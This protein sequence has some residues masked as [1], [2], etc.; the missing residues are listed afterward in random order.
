MD[1]GHRITMEEI[2]RLL[3]PDRVIELKGTTRRQVFS[4]LAARVAADCPALTERRIVKALHSREQTLSTKVS[5]SVAIPHAV[6]PTPRTWVA[7]GRSRA[8]IRWERGDTTRIHIV[9]L[10]TGPRHEHLGAIA[11][12]A[13]QLSRPD[14]VRALLDASGAMDVYALLTQPLPGASAHPG[15][16][17]TNAACFRQAVAL[18]RELGADRLIL[19]ADAVENLDFVPEGGTRP[20]LL[21]VT[22]DPPRIPEAAARAGSVLHIP[23]RGHDRAGQVDAAL[24]Y[25]VSQGALR[26]TD[27]VVSVGGIP[28]SGALDMIRTAD[29]P[30]EYPHVLAPDGAQLPRDLDRQVLL[31]TLQLAARI[32]EEGREGDAVGTLFVVGDSRR[33]QRH[34]R[35]MIIN[36]FR[37]CSDDSRNIMD[38]GLEETVKEFARLDGAF[39][40]AGDGRIVSAGTFL[41]TDATVEDLPAGLGAR[42][43]AAAAISRSTRALSVVVSQSTRRVSL[44][45][46]GRR[47]LAFQ[48]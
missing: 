26:P 11:R 3:S 22:D 27:R 38:P 33:V 35:Q 43:G 31:R 44:F 18:A 10:V 48:P 39:I 47:V 16:A 25:A 19:H 9:A 21:L 12:L 13:R 40:I 5:D 34:C 20:P 6:L 42:H 15:N 32:A 14:Q 41:R 17:R 30:S 37:G 24:L 7:I 28:G 36:P 4:E 46:R 2:G 1:E 29:L 23:F 8:G 45:Q